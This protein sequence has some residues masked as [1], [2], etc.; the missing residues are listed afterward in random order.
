MELVFAIDFICFSFLRIGKFNKK[1]LHS[2]YLN[3]ILFIVGKY[4]SYNESYI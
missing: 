3:I 2:F 1:N 4:F